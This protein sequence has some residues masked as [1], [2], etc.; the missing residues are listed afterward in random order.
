MNSVVRE[1]YEWS[2]IWWDCAND[3]KLPRVLL[4]GD[5][6]SV[7]YGPVV[8]KLLQGKVHVDRLSTSRSVN[9]PVLLKETTMMLEDNHYVAIHLNNG[10]HGFHLDDAAYAT[11]LQ[12]YVKLLK[13][14]GH[15]AKLI[16]A[17]S[18]PI[19]KGNDVHVLAENN[20]V[21]IARNSTAAAVMQKN[22]IPVNDLYQ[23]VIGKADLR[24][25]DGYHYNAG[26]YEVMGKVIT[27]S[28]LKVIE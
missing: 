16:W 13:K 3:P 26:G 21:V 12:E 7:G 19:T 9:D 1:Q 22:G 2:N 25:P 28:L 27:E 10:L 8:T 15:G 23:L 14:Y 24:S 17:A 20:D 5:S 18:T 6:I 4:I 11:G